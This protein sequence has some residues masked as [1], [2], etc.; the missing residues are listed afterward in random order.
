MEALSKFKSDY[1][2]FEPHPEGYDLVL[3][4]CRGD[5]NEI[6]P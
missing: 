3:P 2:A 6:F 4:K 5:N 1:G